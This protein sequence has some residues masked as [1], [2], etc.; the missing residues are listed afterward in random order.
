MY[1]VYILNVIRGRRIYWTFEFKMRKKRENSNI[2]YIVETKQTKM[3]KKEKHVEK[4]SECVVQ[5]IKSV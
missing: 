5:M 1:L 4:V 3:W 2:K